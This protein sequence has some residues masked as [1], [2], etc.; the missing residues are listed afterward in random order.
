MMAI[1]QIQVQEKDKTLL[2]IQKIISKFA[3][4]KL[5]SLLETAVCMLMMEQLKISE[6]CNH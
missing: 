4:L 2:S 1:S 3:I 5:F 6:M